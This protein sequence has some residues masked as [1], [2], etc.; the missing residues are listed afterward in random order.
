[1]D[2]YASVLPTREKG[3]AGTCGILANVGETELLSH[4]AVAFIVSPTLPPL[5]RYVTCRESGQLQDTGGRC[6]PSNLTVHIRR[7]PRGVQPHGCDGERP[8]QVHHA[9]Y[10]AA[11]ED[12]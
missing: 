1:M 10:R 12:L 9:G 8:A 2:V 7:D 11:V 3:S 5:L 6:R 4:T